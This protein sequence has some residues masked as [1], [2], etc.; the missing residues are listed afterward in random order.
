MELVASNA[1]KISSVSKHDI[2]RYLQAL[3]SHEYGKINKQRITKP[4]SKSSALNLQYVHCIY[5]KFLHLSV[6]EKS[7][8]SMRKQS[9]TIKQ[10]TNFSH[11]PRKIPRGLHLQR[12]QAVK[13]VPFTTPY[14]LYACIEYSLHVGTYRQLRGS[15][16]DISPIHR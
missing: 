5:M 13:I 16:G 12:R 10:N 4:N 6:L 3:K 9:Q 2:S 7:F 1:L 11:V 15:S 8:L 14:F